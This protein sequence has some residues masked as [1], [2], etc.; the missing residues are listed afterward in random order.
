MTYITLYLMIS[1]FLL[2]WRIETENQTE[3][4]PPALSPSLPPCFSPPSLLYLSLTDALPPSLP[5][6]QPENLLLESETSDLQIKLADFGAASRIEKP[7]SLTR[8]CGTPSYTAPGMSSLLPSLPPSVSP[9]FHL[10]V[11]LL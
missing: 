4:I 2:R 7:E 10:A 1:V 11:C 3:P 5:P 6:S 9:S 8:Y